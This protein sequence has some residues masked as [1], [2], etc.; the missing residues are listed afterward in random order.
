MR[1]RARLRQELG[2]SLIGGP[3]NVL[4]LQEHHLSAS[5]IWCCGQL[6]QG[7]REMLWLVGFGP[8]GAQGG[9]CISVR[10]SLQA[11]IVDRG[12]IVPGRAIWM[13]IQWR[14][15]RHGFLSIYAPNH[16]S[17]RAAFW[18]Q[19]IDALPSV[20][21]WCIA[22]DFNMIESPEDRQ[23]GSQVRIHGAELAA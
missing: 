16:E 12:E 14:G 6:M 9:V 10:D 19:L 21:A 23:G 5:R 2:Q 20:D 18:T 17:A 3:I 15:L 13:I 7:H 11:S 22:G 4:M 1:Y 8:N